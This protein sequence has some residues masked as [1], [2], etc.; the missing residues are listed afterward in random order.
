MFSLL[1]GLNNLSIAAGWKKTVKFHSARL[2]RGSIERLQV[3]DGTFYLSPSFVQK[4]LMNFISGLYY[5]Q[6]AMY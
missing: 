4:E 5:Q 1:F 2:Y 3:V 6:F